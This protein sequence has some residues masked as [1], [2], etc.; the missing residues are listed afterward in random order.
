MTPP[1]SGCIQGFA[2]LGNEPLED[3]IREVIASLPLRDVE[4]MISRWEDRELKGISGRD[5]SGVVFGDVCSSE[6]DAPTLALGV[7]PE[8]TAWRAREGGCPAVSGTLSHLV[9]LVVGPTEPLR[10]KYLRAARE[11]FA[12]ADLIARLSKTQSLDNAR[13]LIRKHEDAHTG[14]EKERR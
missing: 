12:D 5:E 1:L 14:H 3:A 13:E 9:C 8:G 11:L 7:S 6:I 4:P 10:L 2:L